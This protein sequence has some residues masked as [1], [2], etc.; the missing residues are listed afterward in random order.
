M[1]QAEIRKATLSD[2]P[3]IQNIVKDAYAPYIERIG[4]KPAPMTADY[5][6]LI[7]DGTA[8]VLVA[9]DSVAGLIILVIETD[10]VLVEN[11]AVAKAHQGCG[12]GRKLLDHADVYAR[13]NGLRELRLY[14]NELMHENLVIYPK[15]GWQEYNRAEQDG[16]RRVFMR[17]AL[18]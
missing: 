18:C 1:Y 9:G 13:K 2:V 7:E 14:T 3:E 8:W 17:K 15:L 16:F 6:K 5:A 4:R 12:F 10:H 11:V